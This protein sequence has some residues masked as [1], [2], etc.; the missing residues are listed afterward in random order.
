MTST[1]PEDPLAQAAASIRISQVPAS[2]RVLQILS[3]VIYCLLSAG[4][5]FGYAALKPVLIAEG[6]YSDRCTPAEIEADVPVCYQQEMKLNL[7]FTIAAVATNMCAVIVGLILDR[8]GPRVA[9]LIGSVLLCLGC[10]GF[11]ISKD[12]KILDREFVLRNSNHL[13]M[14]SLAYPASY[15]CIA[16]AGPFIFIPSMNLA[17]TF[18]RHSG[19]ILS[20]LTGAFDSSPAVFL[21]YRLIYQSTFGPISLRSWFI[22]YLIVPLFT[23]LAQLLVMPSQSYKPH[24]MTVDHREQGRGV[25]GEVEIVGGST[26]L[27]ETD[28][29]L[30]KSGHHSE[31]EARNNGIYGA[32]H[33]KDI[34]AQLR[35]FWF[36]G[37]TGFTIV[38]MVRTLLFC[39][40]FYCLTYELRS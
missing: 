27:G 32:M 39:N 23:F 28:A 3:A 9:G 25:R 17:N 5:V 11:A 8:Y 10:F 7:M 29:L 4:I 38:Q 1:S 26:A 2:K 6:V 31:A 30:G 24:D 40:Q 21:A 18:P 15:L 20:L 37:I 13:L 34:G 36:W 33:G 12:V 35:S 22:V 19:L 14:N 16:L